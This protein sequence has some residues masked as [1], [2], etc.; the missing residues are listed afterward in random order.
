M[1]AC[2]FAFCMKGS[3]VG[4]YVGTMESC[5]GLLHGGLVLVVGLPF[6]APILGLT[7]KF[8]APVL[9]LTNILSCPNCEHSES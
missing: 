9:G 6:L 3:P 5:K 2:C 8:L 1:A 4:L 7:S